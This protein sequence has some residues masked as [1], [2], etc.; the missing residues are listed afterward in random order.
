MNPISEAIVALLIVVG[1]L[2]VLLGAIGL[3]RLP[4]FLTRLHGPTKATTLGV[5]TILL[6]SAI[7]FS[8]TAEAGVS[9]HELAIL[10]FLFITAPISA[11]L[12][13]K[14]ALHRRPRAGPVRPAAHPE[15]AP[16]SALPDGKASRKDVGNAEAAAAG[17]PA[18]CSGG[19]DG[20]RC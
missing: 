3:A 11:H 4:D 8:Q 19:D 20:H 14:A 17:P 13:A 1:A 6:A 18:G 16:E 5:G 10:F 7:F 2:F 15:V 9:L 12:L